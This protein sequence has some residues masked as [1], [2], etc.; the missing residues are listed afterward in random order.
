MAGFARKTIEDV[1]VKGKRTLVRVD[2]NVPVKN[3]KVTNDKRLRAT[4][5]TLKYLLDH[6][7]KIILMSHLGRPKGQVKAEYSLEP[8]REA[9]QRLLKQELGKDIDV[10]FCKESIGADAE[11]MAGDLKNGEILLLE[12]VRFHAGEEKNDPELAKALAKLGEVY[13]NDA[14]GT[15]HRAHSSTAGITDHLRP[16]VCGYLLRDELVYLGGAI[17]DPARPYAAIIGGAKISGK[18]DVIDNLLPLVD[19]LLIGGAMMFTFYKAKGMET[20]KSL[21]EADKVELAKKLLE[22]AG[23]KLVLPVDCVISKQFDPE[24]MT[25]GKLDTIQITD[26]PADGIGLDIGP[27]TIE[28]FAQI[29]SPCK[30]II[31]NGPMGVFEIDE[32][33]VG[34]FAVAGALARA[35][36]SGATT[37][38]GGGDSA[39][40]IEKANLEDKVSHVSTGGGASLELLEGKTL[41]G[42]A[43]L[44]EK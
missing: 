22:K 7:A 43:A 1:D 2:F 44:D 30:T 12:N 37:I 36:E 8:V 42:V 4:I 23:E 3:G 27:K 21:V 16:A 33:A 19:R 10:H 34:T 13:V 32:T 40:A 28:T 9:L 38:I 6:D 24:N 20:G 31:W 41:P 35:T 18:I 17:T 39:A 25:V 15:A 11:K 14:F 26:M 29:L 5:P